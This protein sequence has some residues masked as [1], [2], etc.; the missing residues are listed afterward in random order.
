MKN[1][2]VRLVVS[3]Y[4]LFLSNAG[5]AQTKAAEAIENSLA[6]QQISWNKGD[7]DAFMQFYWKSDSLLF[8]GKSG[9]TYGW[10]NTLDNYKKSYPDKAAMGS[11][12]FTLLKIEKLSNKCYSV[13]GKWHLS[14][15]KDEIGGH[16]TLLWK[17]IE[18]KW[19]I[20]QDHSS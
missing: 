13:V 15:L 12:S 10:Q 9:A 7:V 6:A 11:L 4:F 3:C 16:F 18:G 14:R 1:K 2:I 19:L 20:V 8:V 17:K 5:I